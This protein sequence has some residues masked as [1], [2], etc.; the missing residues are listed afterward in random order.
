MRYKITLLKAAPEISPIA[1]AVFIC[2]EIA[3]KL[4][5]KPAADR[6]CSHGSSLRLP[7]GAAFGSLFGGGHWASA[8]LQSR[9]LRIPAAGTARIMATI[10]PAEPAAETAASTKSGWRPVDFPM[11]LG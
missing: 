7:S 3:A 10:P 8:H 11:I 1:G 6:F 5:R 9:T 4:R 2:G